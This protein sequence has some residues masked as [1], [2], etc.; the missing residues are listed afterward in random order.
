MYLY[1]RYIYSNPMQKIRFEN[2][3]CS[4]KHV[5]MFVSN[6]SSWQPIRS[7]RNPTDRTIAPN[8]GAAF[9]LNIQNTLVLFSRSDSDGLL[10]T[11]QNFQEAWRRVEQYY[12]LYPSAHLLCSY[13][14]CGVGRSVSS[15][16]RCIT[17]DDSSTLA[18]TKDGFERLS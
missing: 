1:M 7:I 15:M 9:V 8:S 16:R 12:P 10:M 18:A 17:P 5:V 14:Y 2:S 4:E 6:M 11:R 13:T 3:H